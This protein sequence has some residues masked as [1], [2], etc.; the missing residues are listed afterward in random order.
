MLYYY[1]TL[2]QHVS[3][4]VNKACIQL[5]L[6]TYTPQ[7]RRLLIGIFLDSIHFHFSVSI[8]QYD[9]DCWGVMRDIVQRLTLR[10]ELRHIVQ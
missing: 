10:H 8:G 2:M 1:V 7:L 6:T 3:A 4:Y 5:A 9:P